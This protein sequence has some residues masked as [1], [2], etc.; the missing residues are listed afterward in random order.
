LF[1]ASCQ[2]N[3]GVISFGASELGEGRT[4]DLQMDSIDQ[5][6]SVALAQ[7][8]GYPGGRPTGTCLSDGRRGTIIVLTDIV[9]STRMV[10]RGSRHEQLARDRAIFCT[11]CGLNRVVSRLETTLSI[12]LRRIVRRHRFVCSDAWWMFVLIAERKS[13]VPYVVGQESHRYSTITSIN[14]PNSR[15]RRK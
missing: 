7:S 1:V 9:F 3:L 10:G 15:N 11:Y 12:R 5:R 4:D 6:A 8:T 2:S 14:S 13:G